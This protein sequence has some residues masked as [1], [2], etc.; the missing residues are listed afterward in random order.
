MEKENRND[1]IISMHNQGAT[2]R[3]ISEKT[4]LSIGGVHKVLSSVLD[5]A[6]VMPKIPTKISLIGNEE[7]FDSFGG[8]I[9]TNVNEYTNKD[10]GEVIYLAFVG[11]KKGEHGHFVK[12]NK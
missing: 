12:I 2:V 1:M 9:R 4:K 10:T 3:Q 11:G 5:K 7:R 6:D 8:W